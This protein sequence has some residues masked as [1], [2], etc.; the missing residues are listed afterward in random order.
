MEKV[1]FNNKEYKIEFTGRSG[2]IYLNAFSIDFFDEYVEVVE[3]KIDSFKLARMYWVAM[4]TYSENHNTEFEFESVTDFICSL[5]RFGE[6]SYPD[7]MKS[8]MS[9]LAYCFSTKVEPK[10][11]KSK[12]KKV[13]KEQQ[14]EV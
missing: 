2:L 9:E 4:K 13:A 7:N 6:L 5:K 12:K 10:D 8:I 1:K 11:D 14:S 3:S